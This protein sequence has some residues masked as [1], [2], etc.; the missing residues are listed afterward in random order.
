MVAADSEEAMMADVVD[1]RSDTVTQPT[2]A[3]REAMMSA[4]LGDDVLGDEPTVQALEAKC[5]TL[6]GKEASCFVPSGTMA[7]LCAIRSHTQPGD[8]IIGERSSHF[9][10]YEAGGYA[11]IAG[12]SVQTI[13]GERGLITPEQVQAHIRA[14]NIHYPIS[15]LLVLENTHNAGG[16]TVVPLDDFRALAAV[17]REAGL[18][19][20]LD[21]A[22]LLNAAVAAGLPATAYT[23]LVD[24]STLCFS[25]GLGAPVGSIL[26]G[27]SDV[28]DRARRARKMFGG[29]MR[30]S[31]VLAAAA[32]HALDHHVDR[33]VEDHVNAKRLAEGIAGFGPIRLDPA[34]VETN[35]VFFDLDPE[36][37]T[38]A[39]LAGQLEERRVRL[40][41]L[42]PQRLRAVT[43]LQ[44]SAEQI[45]R[46]IEAFGAILR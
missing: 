45:G 29:G 44:V 18:A 6:L 36:W 31:G 41:A 22:R 1:L 21:G 35:I 40:L 20:H 37:G 2:A 23:D 30:Q 24:T 25:K 28:I 7:N 15:R 12:C 26:A 39:A 27:P 4:P 10:R 33:L 17:A 46:A 14:E 34:T 3:M 32:I 11:A 8:E 13:D 9:F 42:G 16:G 5:A 38:A 19:V 43:H